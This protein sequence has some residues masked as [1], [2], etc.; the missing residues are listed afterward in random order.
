MISD[1]VVNGRQPDSAAAVVAGVSPAEIKELQ[2]ARLPL[3]EEA[4]GA[5]LYSLPSKRCFPSK[6]RYK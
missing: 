5:S 1:P 3:Q 4:V 6:V 2:P